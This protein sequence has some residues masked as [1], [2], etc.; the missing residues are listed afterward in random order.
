MQIAWDLGILAG[1]ASLAS[2][3]LGPL[4]L[5]TSLFLL[6]LSPWIHRLLCPHGPLS[7]SPEP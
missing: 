3:E 1:R 5:G 7:S 6:F 4:S 2:P